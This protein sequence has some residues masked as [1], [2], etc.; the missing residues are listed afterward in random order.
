MLFRDGGGQWQSLTWSQVV[1]RVER[2]AAHLQNLGLMHGDPVAIQ[3]DVSIEWELLRQAILRAGGVVVGI[4]ASASEDNVASI[5]KVTKPTVLVASDVDQVRRLSGVWPHAKVGIV[6]HEKNTSVDTHRFPPELELTSLRAME[7]QDFSLREVAVDPEDPATII[8]TSGSTGT[9]KGIVYSHRQVVLAVAAISKLYAELAD[10]DRTIC[11]LPMAHLY[12]RMINLLAIERGLVSYFVSDAECLPNYL[13]EI[14]PA[15]FVGVPRLFEKLAAEIRNNP[16]ATLGWRK[17]VKYAVTGSAPIDPAVLQFLVEHDLLVLEAYG[18]TENVVPIA[19]STASARRFGSVGRPLPQNNL[20]FS[21]DGEL[22]VKGPGVFQ[23]Y[24]DGSGRDRIDKDGYFSTGDFGFINE[25]GFLFL[26]GRKTDVIKTSAGR[27]IAPGKIESIYQRARLVDHVVVFG[28]GQKRLVALVTLD[29]RQVGRI[30]HAMLQGNDASR[31]STLRSMIRSDFERL[32]ETL[33][34]H[35]RIAEF[36]ILE[37]PFSIRLGELTPTLKLRRERIEQVHRRLLN[38][39]YSTTFEKQIVLD[40]S[41]PTPKRAKHLL[42]TGGTGVVGSSL[43]AALAEQANSHI[44]LLLRATSSAHLRAR[45]QDVL[46]RCK[47]FGVTDLAVQRITALRGDVTK[48]R[49]GLDQSIYDDLRSKLTHIVHTAGVVRLNNDMETARRDA[50]LPMN[51]ILELA[52]GCASSG[53]F[54][55]LDYVSTVGVAGRTTGLVNETPQHPENGYHNTYEAAKAEAEWLALRHSDAGL[56]ITIHRPSMVVGD[57][58]TGYVPS[59][60]VFYHLADFFVGRRT[61]GIVPET[62]SVKLDIIPSDY[63]AMGIQAAIDDES[64]T[65]KILHLCSGPQESLTIASLTE[66]L[67]EIYH[68]NGVALPSLTQIP[69]SDYQQQLPALVELVSAEDSRFLKSLPYFLAYL[70]SDQTFDNRQTRRMLSGLELPPID[71]YLDRIVS[72]YLTSRPRRSALKV[73]TSAEEAPRGTI[74]KDR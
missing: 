9:P 50:V 71:S 31:L 3:L 68:R 28:N 14:Q 73:P 22:L 46:E 32:Q 67:R 36:A 5:L 10:G 23:G 70:E 6:A 49:L 24:I 13:A 37:R 7:S 55:K 52:K 11:W 62:R 42:L 47:K 34:Q 74:A 33:A 25:E 40:E 45:L 18:T 38:D 56:P 35:E 30:P 58:R 19:A 57:S 20:Q 69:L 61:C 16:D 44:Y 43:L 60:Q 17:N 26:T 65:G 8:F 48:P 27:K 21:D 4:D 2:Y 63:V 39:L 41:R 64:T 29:A 54:Q 59:F 1:A 72:S 12:Q 51:R 53:Q 66:T 15:F